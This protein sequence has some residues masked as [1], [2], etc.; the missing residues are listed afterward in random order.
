VFESV[1]LLIFCKLRDKKKKIQW[2]NTVW[3][4]WDLELSN[5]TKNGVYLPNA[6][7]NMQVFIL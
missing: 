3:P 1:N 4:D 5:I 6:Y 2:Y 7:F